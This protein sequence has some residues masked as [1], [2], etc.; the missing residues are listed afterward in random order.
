[1]KKLL[2][3]AMLIFSLNTAQAISYDEQKLL[4]LTMHSS[5]L[6]MFCQY[7]DAGWELVDIGK[8][9]GD[10]AGYSDQQM[11]QLHK[12]IM[13]QITY[14][15]QMQGGLKD[16]DCDSAVNFHAYLKRTDWGANNFNPDDPFLRFQ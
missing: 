3:A 7:P 1:M 4:Y 2:V 11:G 13:A 9:L 8:R 14:R 5:I 16:V 10:Q 12:K 6:L 15:I